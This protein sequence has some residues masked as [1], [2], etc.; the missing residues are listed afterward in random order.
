MKKLIIGAC[1]LIVLLFGIIA[2]FLLSPLGNNKQIHLFILS[3]ENF[4]SFIFEEETIYSEN[5]NKKKWGEIKTGTSS[6]D[7]VLL[8]GEPLSKDTVENGKL[9][10]Y[11]SKQGPKNTNYRVRIVIFDSNNNVLET[12]QEFYLD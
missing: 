12:I 5:F 7:I 2:L 3:Q 10:W 11:Y 1:S 6:D 8:V 4:L 9:Y